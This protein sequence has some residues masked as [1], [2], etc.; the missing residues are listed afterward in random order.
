MQVSEK[1][2]E[3]LRAS[4]FFHWSLRISGI[5]C[6]KIK[7]RQGLGQR[8]IYSLYPSITG[9]LVSVKEIDSFLSCV[10]SVIDRGRCQN[11]ARTKKW[12]ARCSQKCHCILERPISTWNLFVL[13]IEQEENV[14]GEVI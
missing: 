5:L 6:V 10:C 11:V 1:S 12:H 7:K 2:T 13:Y 14:N 3:C 9:N 4:F 8:D